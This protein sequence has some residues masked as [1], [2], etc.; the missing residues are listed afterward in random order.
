[1]RYFCHLASAKDEALISTIAPRLGPQEEASIV[2]AHMS[3][4]DDALALAP[5]LAGSTAPTRRL[6]SW[7]LELKRAQASRFLEWCSAHGVDPMQERLPYGCPAK[8]TESHDLLPGT[9]GTLLA[10]QA[11]LLASG[12]LQAFG[13]VHGKSSRQRKRRAGGCRRYKLAI[14]RQ[15]LFEWFLARRSASSARLAYAQITMQGQLLRDA[16]MQAALRRGVRVQVLRPTL[17]WYLRWR[18]GVPGEPR[19]TQSPLQ[20]H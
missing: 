5:A 3:A 7:P 17:K 16:M 9:S 6:Y 2:A 8:Y 11:R 18:K 10:R 13:V 4:E 12:R 15:E 20:S 14:L 19:I 1:M